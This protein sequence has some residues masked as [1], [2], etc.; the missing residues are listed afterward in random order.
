MN[1]LLKVYKRGNRFIGEITI[2][3]SGELLAKK[4]GRTKTHLSRALRTTNL[5][6]SNMSIKK[7]QT[8]PYTVLRHP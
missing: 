7:V 1:L 8:T 2:V 6:P 5:V 3:E 4:E